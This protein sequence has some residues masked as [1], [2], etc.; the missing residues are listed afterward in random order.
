MTK[1]RWIILSI[2][3][4]I[5]TII[6]IVFA[7]SGFNTLRFNRYLKAS[8]RAPQAYISYE[9]KKGDV[10]FAK[11]SAYMYYKKNGDGYDI[12]CP[13]AQIF[14]DPSAEFT[15]SEYNAYFKKATKLFSKDAE[16]NLPYILQAL[17][18]PSLF[19][20]RRTTDG[21]IDYKLYY[22][23]T[24]YKSFFRYKVQN[25]HGNLFKPVTV[26]VENGKISQ[27]SLKMDI[28]FETVEG[29]PFRQTWEFKIHYDYEKT[30]ESPNANNSDGVDVYT[31]TKIFD[32]GSNFIHFQ[33]FFGDKYY[34][35]FNDLDDDGAVL[36]IYDLKLQ[37]K[38]DKVT[39]PFPAQGVYSWGVIPT[40]QGLYLINQ[41]TCEIWQYNLADK[42]FAVS[43]FWGRYEIKAFLGAKILYWLFDG[44]TSEKTGYYIAESLFEEPQRAAEYDQYDEVYYK[45]GNAY[46][47]WDKDGVWGLSLLTEQ[48]AGEERIELGEMDAWYFCAD[49]I[50]FAKNTYVS[51]TEKY[52][53]YRLYNWDL[54]FVKTHQTKG[55]MGSLCGETEDFVYYNTFVYDKAKNAYYWTAN[56]I[57]QTYI[58]LDG[59]FYATDWGKI[60]SFTPYTIVEK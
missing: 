54:S 26:R 43:S 21:G 5:V 27:V 3:I 51:E 50:V 15:V 37:S 17:K 32:S 56:E 22:G 25:L 39:L 55:F 34:G 30:L 44:E 40:E 20:T 16:I 8:E 12:S 47:W 24:F 13:N 29:L 1:K 10:D 46:A 52:G 45:N 31:P 7:V 18:I 49:G 4:C 57:S 36:I 14:D 48:G 11:A 9:Y 42:S 23:E 53:E 35:I 58:K 2:A 60:Y 38:M 41:D 33:T 19:A 59:V 28:Q 6:E